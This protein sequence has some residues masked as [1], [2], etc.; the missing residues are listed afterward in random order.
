MTTAGRTTGR[1]PRRDALLEQA[2]AL[3]ATRGYAAV[4]VDDIGAA[5]GITGPGVYR[6]FPSKQAILA[7]LFDDATGR[8]LA[9]AHTVAA[10]PDPVVDKLRT[11]VE[12]HA[13]LALSDRGLISVY[14]A[15]E[16]ALPEDARKRQRAAQRSYVEHWLQLLQQLRPALEPRD[17]LLV[18]QSVIGMLNSVAFHSGHADHDRAV[19][20][21]TE[22]GL[23]ALLGAPADGGR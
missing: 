5:A 18:V 19:A 1:R 7:A 13:D 21:L 16:H 14:L 2:A 8:L 20:L 17:V 12:A 10:S 3:F 23:A 15:E 9:V 22:T 11:L 4:G 6:H